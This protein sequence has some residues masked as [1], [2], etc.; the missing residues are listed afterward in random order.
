MIVSVNLR[1]GDLGVAPGWESCISFILA[2]SEAILE[3]VGLGRLVPQNKFL[4]SPW[5]SRLRFSLPA[6]YPVLRRRDTSLELHDQRR[7]LTTVW[8]PRFNG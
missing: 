1:L 3:A 5:R 2:S 7:C 4:N 8:P 6:R